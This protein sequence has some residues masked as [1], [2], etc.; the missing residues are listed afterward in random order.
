MSHQQLCHPAKQTCLHTSSQRL[1][2]HAPIWLTKLPSAVHCQ[3]CAAASLRHSPPD[4]DIFVSPGLQQRRD[5]AQ[6]GA[7][8][9]GVAPG[10]ATAARVGAGLCLGPSY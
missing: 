2:I 4:R 8:G 9:G 5:E 7:G 6:V 1:P 3:L 10:E